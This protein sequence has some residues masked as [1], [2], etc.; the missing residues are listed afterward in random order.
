MLHIS[1]ISGYRESVKSTNAGFG[2]AIDVVRDNATGNC[3]FFAYNVSL[4]DLITNGAPNRDVILQVK[5][6]SKYRYEKRY[7]DYVEWMK[8]NAWC[9]EFI[10][11]CEAFSNLDLFVKDISNKF[12]V[13]LSISKSPVSRLILTVANDNAALKE[14]SKKLHSDS[15]KTTN[16]TLAALAEKLA[17]NKMPQ[18]INETGYQ[19][20]ATFD[21]NLKNWKNLNEIIEALKLHGIVARE[22]S[23][24]LAEIFTIKE[25]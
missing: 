21:F 6:A 7:G 22:E 10:M 11:P 5:D 1:M 4:Q 2:M 16:M 15:E 9:Y 13:H 24:G 23:A 25:I 17:L 8:K 14:N 20:S 18:I 3:K 19:D 12:G